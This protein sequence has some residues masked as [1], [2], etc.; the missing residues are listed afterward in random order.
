MKSYHLLIIVSVAIINLFSSCQEKLLEELTIYSNDFSSMDLDG[1][2]S[3]E[4]LYMYNNRNVL[5]IFNNQGFTLTI[6]NLP[7]HNMVRISLDLYIHNYWNGNSQGVE[8]PDIWNMHIDNSPI[9]HTTFANTSCS[10]TYCQYQSFPENMVRSFIPKTEAYDSNLPGLFD[11]R[12]NLG[13]TTLY[14]INKIIPHNQ[15]SLSIKCYDQLIQENVPVPKEDE[16]WSVGKIEV[17]ILN[18]N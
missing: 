10:S 14:K 1:I 3:D 5:G 4:G 18:V 16:S 8:G 15:A 9:I 17:S 13:W 2:D 7:G 12:S 11:Q 6:N